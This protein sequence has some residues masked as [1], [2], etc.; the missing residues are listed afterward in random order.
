[1]E[2]DA[3]VIG[4]GQAGLATGYFLKQKKKKFLIINEKQNIG[5][6]WRERYDSLILFTPRSFSAL[7][8]L[9][10]SG[11]PQ[12]YPT[13]DEMADYLYTYATH[14]ELPVLNNMK[15]ISLKRESS[16]FILSMQN[17]DTYRAKQVVVATGGFHTPFTPAIAQSISRDVFQMHASDYRRPD[18]IPPGNVLIV[19]AGNTGVQIAA[20]LSET[21]QV[22][23]AKGKKIKALPQSIM[24]K[25]L[26]WWLDLLGILDVKIT[27]RLGKWIRQRDPVIGGDIHKVK[28]NVTMKGRLVEV[29]NQTAVFE[30]ESRQDVQSILWAT[31]YRNDY[32]WIDIEGILD[33]DGKPIHQRGVS[34]I[35]GLYFVGLSWQYKRGSALI[36][37]VGE[38]AEFLVTNMG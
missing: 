16:S 12:G 22:T 29:D 8:G 37:G 28:K 34:T 21:H 14:F 6:S 11:D 23:L 17:G 5:D 18:Q 26:F 20:E 38:D 31:G 10:L 35:Q 27:S 36:H 7:P 30:D 24:G 25:D 33:Q 15:V 1:M 3:I 32:S 19:G 13:K 2:Y 9:Q 4:G